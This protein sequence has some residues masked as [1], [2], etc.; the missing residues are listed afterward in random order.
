MLNSDYRI[1]VDDDTTVLN[2]GNMPRGVCPGVMLSTNL[3]RMVGETNAF[4]AYLQDA[5]FS[6]PEAVAMGLVNE[7]QPS[8]E[9]AIARA[10][11]LARQWAAAPRMGVTNTLK[12]MRPES[13]LL[14]DSRLDSEAL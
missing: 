8:Y 5:F 14:N 13:S 3:P 10:L 12:L 6:P 11:G 4:N 9:A 1:L 2:Y 7:S